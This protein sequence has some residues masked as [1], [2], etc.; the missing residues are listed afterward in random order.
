MSDRNCMYVVCKS[1]VLILIIDVIILLFRMANA[2]AKAEQAD[3]AALKA[4][5]DSDT[6]R[7]KA[8]QY[9]PEFHQ[10]GIFKIS[11]ILLTQ[12]CLSV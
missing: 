10:P 8:K 6:A 5:Q 12:L 2:R 3:Q 4:E 7:L 9:A 1:V 11:I